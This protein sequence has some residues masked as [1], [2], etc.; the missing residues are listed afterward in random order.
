MNK[1]EKI[2]YLIQTVRSLIDKERELAKDGSADNIRINQIKI[3]ESRLDEIS[4]NLNS[5]AIPQQS[6]RRSGVSKMI[7]DSW[8]WDSELAN[9]TLEIEKIYMS[10]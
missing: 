5:N 8:P 4:K 1:I 3:I 2:F 7:V 10:L 6:L 9:L